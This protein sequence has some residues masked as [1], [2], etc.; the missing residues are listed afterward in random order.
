MT[1]HKQIEYIENKPKNFT[2]DNVINYRNISYQIIQKWDELRNELINIPSVVDATISDSYPGDWEGTG[3]TISYHG[4]IISINE[5]NFKP[6]YLNVFDIKLIEGRF[7]DKVGFQEK[8]IVLNESAVKELGIEDPVG[9][10]LNFG[11]KQVEIIGVVKDYNYASLKRNISPLM[12][13]NYRNQINTLSL[14]INSANPQEIIGRIN[15]SIERYDSKYS[16]N[17]SFLDEQIAQMYVS[18]RTLRRI[19]Y[20]GNLMGIAIA[21]IG[22]FAF[23]TLIANQRTKEIGIRKVCGATIT[24]LVKMFNWGFLK[25]VIVAFI[26]ASPLAYFVMNNWLI[27]FAYKT[28]L[29][30][31]IFAIAGL[32]VL[33]IAL[34]TISFQSWKIASQ[35]PVESLRYE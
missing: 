8:A 35:N 28:S 20:L 14:K 4:N 34:F 15:T 23:A 12:M 11:N 26:I 33:L 25:W 27:N 24:E 5:A 17:Y 10:Y 19:F 29:S 1:V 18:E 6:G 30:W 3:Q 16:I 13:V 21:L 31:W 7:F 32:F 2:A 22:L 9:E